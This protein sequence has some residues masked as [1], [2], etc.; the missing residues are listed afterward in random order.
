MGWSVDYRSDKV[1][2][3]EDIQGIVDNL[4]EEYLGM[5][6]PKQQWGWLTAVGIHNPIG[7]EISIG[8]SYGISGDIAERF[9][10]YF[11]RQLK[12]RGHKTRRFNSW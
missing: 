5:G 6:F 2:T 3:Q 4:P 12:K 8:G 7:N 9:A 10:N 1:I 11:N